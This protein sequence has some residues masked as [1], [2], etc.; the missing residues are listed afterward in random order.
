[1]VVQVVVEVESVLLA[2]Q[3]A[4]V[5]QV[6]EPVP[7]RRDLMQLCRLNPLSGRMVD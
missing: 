7:A 6:A 1:M 2:V 4:L 3:V 5:A